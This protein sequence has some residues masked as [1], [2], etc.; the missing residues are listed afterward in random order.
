MAIQ[1]PEYKLHRSDITKTHDQALRFGKITLQ[2]NVQW[3]LNGSYCRNQKIV[4]LNM[5]DIPKEKFQVVLILEFTIQ[6]ATLKQGINEDNEK[7]S[8][9]YTVMMSHAKCSIVSL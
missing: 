3:K 4:Q 8:S 1:L 6:P 7:C 2:K 5:T 9:S